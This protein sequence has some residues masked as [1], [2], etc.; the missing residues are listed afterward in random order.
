M[1]E[2][3]RERE[4]SNIFFYREE[5]SYFVLCTFVT[6][7]FITINSS[8]FSSLDG[9]VWL[10]FNAV[11]PAQKKRGKRT[12]ALEFR[13]PYVG[14]STPCEAGTATVKNLCSLL[15]NLPNRRDRALCLPFQGKA[16][17]SPSCSPIIFANTTS[18]PVFR[19]APSGANNV[20]ECSPPCPLS[21]PFL[22]ASSRVRRVHSKNFEERSL[23][24]LDSVSFV[25]D[26][27]CPS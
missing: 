17:S 26:A 21:C 12:T 23:A 2:R 3:E 11:A 27:S 19:I 6:R 20:G 22:T 18:C 13:R 10:I 25:H 9:N 24:R 8:Q 4:F 7:I 15:A 5:S 14:E 1:L 16:K